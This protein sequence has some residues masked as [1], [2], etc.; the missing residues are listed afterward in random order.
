MITTKRTVSSVLEKDRKAKQSLPSRKQTLNEGSP[1]NIKMSF[2]YLQEVF[3]TEIFDKTA[4][5]HSL[6]PEIVSQYPP[7]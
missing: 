6:Y 3:L 1:Q 7:P 5:R 4:C 2:V